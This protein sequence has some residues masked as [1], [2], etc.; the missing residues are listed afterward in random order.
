MSGTPSPSPAPLNCTTTNWTGMCDSSWV[1]L[2]VDVISTAKYVDQECH[3][4]P[5]NDLQLRRLIYSRAVE[6]V[7]TSP[8]FSKASFKVQMQLQSHC[9]CKI[10][11][12]FG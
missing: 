9:V 10:F 3:T 12:M 4:S 6:D 7:C 8:R 2:G 11:I 1:N 5:D